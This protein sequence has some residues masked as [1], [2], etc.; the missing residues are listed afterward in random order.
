MSSHVTT[1]S[2]P[3]PYVQLG[4]SLSTRGDGSKK[5]IAV[6]PSSGTKASQGSPSCEEELGALSERNTEEER[7]VTEPGEVV[8][9]DK[10]QIAATVK[11]DEAVAKKEENETTVREGSIGAAVSEDLQEGTTSET[12]MPLLGRT[13]KLV[14]DMTSSFQALLTHHIEVSGSNTVYI[15]CIL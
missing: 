5:V 14:Q 8:A 2:P 1:L 13:R 6:L 9:S 12:A 3:Y 11:E 7:A 15:Q 4:W 10:E